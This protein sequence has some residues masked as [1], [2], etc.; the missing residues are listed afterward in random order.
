[1]KISR[2]DLFNLANPCDLGRLR[3]GTNLEYIEDVNPLGTF[4]DKP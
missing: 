1:M 2:I 3:S 4:E